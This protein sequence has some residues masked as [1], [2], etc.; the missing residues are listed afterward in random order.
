MWAAMVLLVGTR[1]GAEHGARC[2]GPL[3]GAAP[4]RQLSVR[5]VGAPGIRSTRLGSRR[6]IWRAGLT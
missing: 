2:R 4:A 5:C 3:Q 6:R 1:A